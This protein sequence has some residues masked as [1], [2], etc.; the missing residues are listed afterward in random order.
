MSCRIEYYGD[1]GFGS[2]MSSKVIC[3]KTERVPPK[4]DEA[5]QPKADRYEKS[6]D[7]DVYMHLYG[8]TGY[9]G[10]ILTSM[11]RTWMR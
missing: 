4:Q 2:F 8:M 10:L 5:E 6:D 11:W 1:T 3:G 9:A 7:L